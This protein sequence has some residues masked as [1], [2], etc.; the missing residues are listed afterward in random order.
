[1]T[2]AVYDLHATQTTLHPERGI[3]RATAD[4]A[5]AL[6]AHSPEAMSGYSYLPDL[7]LPVGLADDLG[8]HRLLP[9]PS[10]RRGQVSLFHVGSAFEGTSLTDLLPLGARAHAT[11]LAVTLF[12]LIPLHLPDHYLS[13]PWARRR[14]LTRL[15][16]VRH[17][18]LVLAI[19]E[20]TAR[21]GV[22][23]L[24]LRPDRVIVTGLAPSPRF[25]PAATGEDPFEALR[26]A[27][28]AIRRG[29]ILYP[30]GSDIRKN[31]HGLLEEYALLDPEQRRAHQLVVACRLGD[32]A[33][34]EL[35]AQVRELS[36]GD[37]VLAVGVVPD[38]VLVQLYQSTHLVVFPSLHE[39]YGLPVME[40]RRCGAPVLASG[41]TAL[42][43]LLP[44]DALFDP[45]VPGDISRAL[46]ETLDAPERLAHLRQA[47]EPDGHTWPEVAARTVA[48]Y[49]SVVARRSR[50]RRPRPRLAVVSPLPPE[51]TGVADHTVHLAEELARDASVELFTTDPLGARVSLDLGVHH[52]QHLSRV[53]AGRGA[54]DGIVHA[55]G[56]SRFH[57]A[58]LPVMRTWPGIVIAHD[59]AVAG[60]YDWCGDHHPELTGGTLA[61]ALARMYPDDLPPAVD[62]ATATYAEL[63]R[64]GIT[65]ARE[66]V[67]WAERYLVH[68]EAAAAL[69]R[70][71]LPDHLHARVGVLPFA[72]RGGRPRAHPER[73]GHPPLV[74]SFGV[75][76][77][78]KRYELLLDAFALV[79]AA[80]PRTRLVFVGEVLLGIRHRIHER[81]DALGIGP[82]V[83]LT[84]RVPP[85]QYEDWLTAADVAVQL[86]TGWNGE[87]S[88]ALG[89]TL[90]WGIPTITSAVGS[91]REVPDDA[92]RKVG[93]SVDARSLAETIVQLLTDPR[94]RSSLSAGGVA[95]AGSHTFSRT[96]EVILDLIR[97]DGS[98]ASAH[99]PRSVAPAPA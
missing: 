96:A 90:A 71:D 59:V 21:D 93:D 58:M 55:W 54:F 99:P 52:L 37:D 26:A 89:D 27:V 19:S 83:L 95:Y 78:S 63:D 69:V 72:V 30:G 88:A 5:R 11:A 10:I 17:A 70:R 75:N 32:A 91:A 79:H 57:A 85:E 7:A 18:D 33:A 46:A 3:A 20:H 39:G 38:D 50:R 16:L 65:L 92:V 74:V 98:R 14:Y 28:P 25:A 1:L 31:L 86:R 36:L 29:F 97:R 42:V 53:Q 2:G 84:G 94:L 45:R 40:A 68:S 56:N 15:E 87:S 77:A 24:G 43:E 62:P 51:A 60:L 67:G 44:D 48:A 80:D 76:Q 49:R 73:V 4:L 66:V 22:E 47:P 12:D 8:R 23:L 81:A 35:A 61:D 41:L 13:D 6:E 64:H 9:A 34:Q 82:S